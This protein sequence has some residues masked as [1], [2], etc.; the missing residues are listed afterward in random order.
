ML[1]LLCGWLGCFWLVVLFRGGG[2]VICLV[3]RCP[4][5][6]RVFLAGDALVACS[7]CGFWDT[8]VVENVSQ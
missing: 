8:V 2:S 5:C 6:E 3:M 7:V 1:G 4:Y